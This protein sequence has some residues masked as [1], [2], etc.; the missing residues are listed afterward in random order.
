M[1]INTYNLIVDKYTR[2]TRLQV[3]ESYFYAQNEFTS[4]EAIVM[5]MKE[6]FQL[7]KQADEYVYMLAFNV[8]MW[9]LGI[10]E[11][12]HGTGNASLLDARGVFVRALQ[13]GANNVILVHNHP[14]GNASPSRDDLAI[15]RRIKEAG[16]IIGI[17][18]IDHVIIG[19]CEHVSLHE[20]ELL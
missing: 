17:P 8:K 9:L 15:S 3:K 11:I 6:L 1:K 19:G 14:S 10:F 18:L 16:N 12:S 2:H 5:L 7:Q 4:S 13:I 20:K